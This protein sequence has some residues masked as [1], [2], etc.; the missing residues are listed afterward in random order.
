[1]FVDQAKILVKS[2]KGGDGIIAWRRE[3]YIQY[4]GPFGG[5]GG[6][7]GSIIF[8]ADE[9]LSTLLDFRFRKK[10]IA[11][12]GQ[13]GGQKNCTG[14]D[15]EDI[16]VK[17]P[18]GTIVFNEETGAV[19][20]DLTAHNQEFVVARGGKGGRGNSHF[21][22][23]KIQ[24][25]EI[26]ENGQPGI[27]LNLRL[28]LKL[29]A[30]VG[31]VGFPS[32]GKSTLISVVSGA[33]P[34]IGDYPFTTLIPN[35]GVVDVEGIRSF[36]MAD[37]PGIIEGASQ[38][39]GLG[40]QFLRHIER[41]RVIVHIIDVSEYSGRDPYED[42]QII[43]HELEEYK[44]Q[45]SQR[46]Q[47]IV[48]N[49]MDAPGAA[50]RFAKLKEQLG[51]DKEIIPISALTK[52]GLKPLLNRIVELLDT[53]PYFNI[54]EDMETAEPTLYTLTPEEKGFTVRRLKDHLYEVFGP[55][56]DRLVEK[57][58]FGNDES[59]KQLSRSLRHLGVDDELRKAGVSN[60]DMVR[61]VDYE[62][63]FVD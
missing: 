55:K 45:L 16:Y 33:R 10:I 18:V 7:G 39:V 59:I 22:T 50:E 47:V 5:D 4:G 8:R 3:K 34:K 37:M 40:L 1:M 19:I 25:P 62:F 41:T 2:G 42:Y 9:G 54:Y 56:I 32:V 52:T 24:A 48:A 51:P 43:N 35:L 28:E 11:E 27:A 15:A 29:L 63:E 61:I 46:P 30:D 20:C 13:N 36:V 53:T 58:L 38:G 31:L 23:P 12:P 26:Q 21:A 6:K 17:V 44:F 60:G 49:K 14:A 57:T